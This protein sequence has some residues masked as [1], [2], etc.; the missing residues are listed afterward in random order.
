MQCYF[1]FMQ[2]VYTGLIT[3]ASFILVLRCVTN[4]KVL[5]KLM[6]KWLNKIRGVLSVAH[7]YVFLF[8]SS[9]S[10]CLLLTKNGSDERHRGIDHSVRIG[11]VSLTELSK[12]DPS[13]K[14]S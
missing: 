7:K 13:S 14:F 3:F 5:V 1:Y 9:R 12:Y 4:Y 6:K 10:V 8:S 11:T 2:C